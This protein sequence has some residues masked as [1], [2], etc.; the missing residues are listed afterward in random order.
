[1]E[2]FWEIIVSN[3]RYS[4]W[5]TILNWGWYVFIID[6]PRFLILEIIVLFVT[7]RNRFLSK[8]K[9]ERAHTRMMNENPLI[10]VLVALQTIRKL[11]EDLLRKKDL[12]LNSYAPKSVAEKHLQPIS[13]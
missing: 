7:F 8:E 2:N 4:D 9:W 11:S 5:S 13:V 6:I 3:I 1:V 10:T 12:S